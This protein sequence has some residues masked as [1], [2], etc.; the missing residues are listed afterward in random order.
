[1]EEMGFLGPFLIWL[2]A[3]MKWAGLEMPKCVTVHQRV[4]KSI[5]FSPSKQHVLNVGTMVQCD[6]CSMW[7]LLLSKKKL[8]VSDKVQLE[9][10]LS[11][12]SYTC[13]ST[14]DDIELPDNLKGVVVHI[15]R[16]NDPV[17]KLYYSAV[18]M[19]DQLK[20]ESILNVMTVLISQMFPEDLAGLQVNV[21]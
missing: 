18:K 11:D 3:P 12:I 9:S 13:G 7:H 8:S 19:L 4:K 2:G 1:M 6:E 20:L 10:I 16:C 21:F 14:F 17:E 5:P 15:H